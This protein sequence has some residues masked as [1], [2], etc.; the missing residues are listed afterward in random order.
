MICIRIHHVDGTN[1]MTSTDNTSVC[2]SHDDDI[3]SVTEEEAAERPVVTSAGD[4]AN[5]LLSEWA[6]LKVS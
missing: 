6:N 4:L 1:V 5:S 2:M 3:T